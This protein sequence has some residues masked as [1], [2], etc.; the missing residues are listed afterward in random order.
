MK[1]LISVLSLV[2]ANIACAM[3]IHTLTK[4]TLVLRGEVTEEAVSPI[5]EG[6]LRSDKKDVTIFLTSPGGSVFAGAILIDAMEASG[7][8]ITCITNFSA[9]MSFAILQ[10]CTKRLIT[11]SGVVMQHVMS[12]EQQG[13]VPNLLSKIKFMDRMNEL[14]DRKQAKRIGISY[15]EFRSKVRDDYWVMGEDAVKANVVDGVVGVT[16]SKELT[17]TVVNVP[18]MTMFGPMEIPFSGCPLITLPVKPVNKEQPPEVKKSLS[19]KI[20]FI[21]AFFKRYIE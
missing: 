5:I 20:N 9:S 18:I 11:P 21:E 19:E 17:N 15:E 10:S 1:S 14:Q 6:I 2:V 4:D 7:K 3:P 8:N 16:C 12:G 13:Q